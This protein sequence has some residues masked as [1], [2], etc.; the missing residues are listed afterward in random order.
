M[1]RKEKS[2]MSPTNGPPNLIQP[3]LP[4]W[5][6]VRRSYSSYFRH[7]SDLL[8]ASWLWLILVAPL[9][10]ISGWQ[11][12]LSTLAVANLKPGERAQIT[13]STAMVVIS[14]LHSIV[15]L[16]AGV[17]IAVAWHRRII[18]DERPAISGRNVA[19]KASWHYFA[20]A[21]ALLLITFLPAAAVT[22]YFLWPVASLAS[23]PAP[24]LPLVMLLVGALYVAG[25][26]TG[27]RLI[28][29]LPARAIGNAGLS[30]G[31]TWN[32][33]RGNIWRLFWGLWFTVAPPLLGIQ[34]AFLIVGGFPPRP[35]VAVGDDFVAH[36]TAFDTIIMT[37]CPLILPIGIG[38]I[39][40]AYQHFF[41]API[42]SAG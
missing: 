16:L 4:V 26:A 5:A 18:L 12:W 17:S 14:S 10:G 24:G 40:H 20:V 32:R 36:M 27:L 42:A 23:S 8:S 34:I 33:T 15:F 38:F 19:T 31:Q 3:E 30:F 41:R 21:L 39:S 35:D 7:F 22:L 13:Q 1:S 25:I 6:M 29:L 28:L 9:T 11:Q 37:C 2:A